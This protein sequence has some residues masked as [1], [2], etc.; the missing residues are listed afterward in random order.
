M[1]APRGPTPQPHISCCNSK[2]DGL[3]AWRTS[4]VDGRYSTEQRGPSHWN[5][6]WTHSAPKSDNE[7]GWHTL[8]NTFLHFS[9][10][11]SQ[12]VRHPH[13][14]AFNVLKI[15]PTMV[16]CQRQDN[17]LTPGR[18]RFGPDDAN[19][20]DF[21]A[22]QTSCKMNLNAPSWNWRVFLHISICCPASS[23]GQAAYNSKS[24]IV[25]PACFRNVQFE[26]RA[27]GGRTGP[28]EAET[29]IQIVQSADLI[30]NPCLMVPITAAQTSV[31][32]EASKF[33]HISSVLQMFFVTDLLWDDT[34]RAQPGVKP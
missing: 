15:T 23:S 5:F 16:N 25:I 10:T 32:A 8:S 27:G 30:L 26:I 14:T 9:T 29:Q 33:K 2:Q 7:L 11:P 31:L 1:A 22:V 19:I 20:L 24:T 18:G 4:Q 17:V 28:E 12:Q 34:E 6:E 21:N 3:E 13:G